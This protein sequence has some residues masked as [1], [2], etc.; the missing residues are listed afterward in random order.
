MTPYGH[1]PGETIPANPISSLYGS[2]K[3]MLW[4]RMVTHRIAWIPLTVA[5]AALIPSAGTTWAQPDATTPPSDASEAIRR[6]AADPMKNRKELRA[7][8]TMDAAQ[9]GPAMSLVLADSDLRAG[10]RTAAARRF[11]EVLA[12]HPTPPWNVWAHLGLGSIAMQNDDLESARE[13]YTTAAAEDSPSRNL[14][15][16]VLG[17]IDAQSDDWVEAKARFDEV[18]ASTFAGPSLRSAAL[19]GHAY[20]AYWSGDLREAADAFAA[21][22]SKLAD[23]R[24][25]DDAR[26]GEAIARW[27]LGEREDALRT[28]RVLAAETREGR[29]PPMT[30]GLVMLDNDALLK[31]GFAD[32]RRA[33]LTSPDDK[34]A[35]MF[36][37]DSSAMA[38]AALRS[39]GGADAATVPA[40]A[41][42]VAPAALEQ[43]P[44]PFPS[45]S[46][47]AATSGAEPV[48]SYLTTALIALGVL[49]AVV[50]AIQRRGA[51]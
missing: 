9:A 23:P 27:R 40:A 19:L 20:V 33:P 31:T 45:P 25:H 16:F 50:L 17:I 14:A 2:A 39:L 35:A 42:V 18:S 15:L 28:L 37:L 5:L 1:H 8:R 11:E 34:M 4:G 26:Y 10:R 22:P 43:S 36:D 49:V 29:R 24:Y 21:A 46:H 47:K 32:Y 44:P 30:N 51:V 48:E 41:P 7:F 3:S 13:H 6:Y 38:R 12:T